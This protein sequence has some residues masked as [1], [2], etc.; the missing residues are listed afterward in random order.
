MTNTDVMQSTGMARLVPLREAHLDQVL[1]IEAQTSPAG[2]T[3]A[4]F[5]NELAR[6]DTRCY[7]VA[8]LAEHG[9]VGFAGVQLMAGE[10]HITTIAVARGH[11]RRKLATRLLVALLREARAR[12][13]HAATLEVRLH[14][15]AAQ[16]LYATVGF[17]PVGVRPR[18]Y[19]GNA[20]AI[21]MWA[22]DIDTPAFGATLDA[23]A[24]AT[25][26]PADTAHTP[27]ADAD[28]DGGC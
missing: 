17:R 28:R 21:I 13:A 12:G 27:R 1:D 14:N 10:A 7:L 8:E 18:Y 23:L 3:R 20:D 4:I 11:R 22:H 16:R 24:T 9:V 2:W 26:S 19:D 6:P 5:R 15:R 25:T